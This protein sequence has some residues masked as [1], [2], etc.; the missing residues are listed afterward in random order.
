LKFFFQF[1]LWPHH[2]NPHDI[3]DKPA[4]LHRYGTTQCQELTSYIFLK[5][6][7]VAA[8]YYLRFT[9]CWC[10][11]IRK[12]KVYQQT[13]F[14]R[15]ISIDGWD[16]TTSV[17]KNKRPPYWNSTSGFDFEHLA[18]ICILLCISKTNFVQIGAPIA[19]IWRH[20]N[21]LRWRPRPL[22]TT[23]GFVF[24]DVTALRMSKSISKPNFVD[25][26]QLVAEI[27]TSVFEKQTSAI[28]EFYFRFRSQPLPRYLHVVVHQ[29]TEFRPNLSIHGGNMK[30][31]PFLKMAAATAKYYF[32]FR[33][34]WCH[35]LQK[36]KVYQQPNFV[37]ISQL[38]IEIQLLLFLKN[39]R[40][41][42]SNSTSGFDLDH[43]LVICMLLCIRLPNFVQ[44]WPLNTTSCFVFV[45]VTAFRRSKSISKPNFVDISQLTIE[46]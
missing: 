42:Y 8:Q 41:L 20:N 44:M 11:C 19:E 3:L 1:W 26:S 22:N 31:Y 33:I 21:F 27:T 6:A 38:T 25:I 17:L 23:S 29:A 45:N 36:L 35:C 9:T 13:K 12:V 15:R 14:R 32:R 7:S 30:S 24:V 16:M 2:C 46:I 10:H 37:D 40:L 39:K 28:F 18:V 34:C 43:F 4:K 5:M